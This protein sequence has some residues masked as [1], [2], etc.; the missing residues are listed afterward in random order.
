MTITELEPEKYLVYLI[1]RLFDHQFSLLRFMVLTAQFINSKHDEI[2]WQKV[3]GYAERFKMTRLVY[4]VL[5]LLRELLAA[6][7]PE[8]YIQHRITGTFCHSG[9]QNG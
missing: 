8:K 2:D 9:T 5:K 7:V 6:N 1:F 3:V 4:F